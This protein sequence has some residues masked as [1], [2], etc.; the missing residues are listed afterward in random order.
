MTSPNDEGLT[1]CTGNAY[2]NVQPNFT[3]P[4][5]CVSK[6]ASIRMPEVRTLSELSGTT[7]CSIDSSSPISLSE[8]TLVDEMNKLFENDLFKYSDLHAPASVLC[9]A[10]SRDSDVN[11]EL[12]GTETEDCVTLA[13]AQ[14]TLSI[15]EINELFC[16]DHK[17]QHKDSAFNYIDTI[18]LS[19]EISF[20]SERQQAS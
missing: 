14:E 1:E 16:I 12:N 9:I 13:Y 4:S 3:Q 19:H 7:S 11:M 2:L 5:S 18:T 20:D 10:N 15:I 8:D 6:C 17:R